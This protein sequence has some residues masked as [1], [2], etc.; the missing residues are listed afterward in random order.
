MKWKTCFRVF[1]ILLVMISHTAEGQGVDSA[2]KDSTGMGGMSG[3]DDMSGMESKRDSLEAASGRTI[4]PMMK[5][6]MMPGLRS[7]DARSRCTRSTAKHRVRG[8]V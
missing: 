7:A 6:P 3:M 1:G 4:V 2:R 5:S 8:S